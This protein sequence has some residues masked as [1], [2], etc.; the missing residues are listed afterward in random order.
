[1]KDFIEALNSKSSDQERREL[2][3]NLAGLQRPNLS[4]FFLGAIAAWI[5]GRGRRG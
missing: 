3:R 1:M 4:S 2:V 5:L